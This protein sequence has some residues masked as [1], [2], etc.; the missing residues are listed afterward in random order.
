MVIRMATQMEVHQTARRLSKRY[1]RV[2]Y[3]LR[4]LFF[5]FVLRLRR[6]PPERQKAVQPPRLLRLRRL[7]RVLR[8][9]CFLRF[10]VC[11]P[12]FCP[13]LGGVAVSPWAVAVLA[14]CVLPA[15]PGVGVNST[16]LSYCDAIVPFAKVVFPTTDAEFPFSGPAT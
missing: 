3:F 13:L 10:F 15:Y 7:W 2:L 14:A 1:L 16:S 12:P 9:L 6:R 4:V 5:L 11:R 8:F